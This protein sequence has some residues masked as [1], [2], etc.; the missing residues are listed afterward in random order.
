M[1]IAALESPTLVS[2]DVHLK[3]FFAADMS[4]K[5]LFSGG[6]FPNVGSPLFLVAIRVFSSRF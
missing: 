5:S 1:S 6:L 2:D 3:Q 4:E